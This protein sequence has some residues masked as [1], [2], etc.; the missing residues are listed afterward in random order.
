[1]TCFPVV[2]AYH[3]LGHSSRI[4][5]VWLS[6]VMILSAMS[7]RIGR[8]ASADDG[9]DP[10]ESVACIALPAPDAGPQTSGAAGAPVAASAAVPIRECGAGPC[11][12]LP[13]NPGAAQYPSVAVPET[14]I[15]SCSTTYP[16]NWCGGPGPFAGGSGQS[17]SVA[18][19]PTGI[20][21][22]P[23]RSIYTTI[24]L[25]NAADVRALRTLSSQGL[26]PYWRGDALAQIQSQLAQLQFSGDNATARLYSIQVQDA[27]LDLLGYTATVHTME[28]WLYQERS[29]DSGAVLFSQDEWVRN[30]YDLSFSG[31]SWYITSNPTSLVSGPVPYPVFGP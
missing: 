13:Y 12:I 27:T 11:C 10:S 29:M 22:S 15:G 28:H 4:L 30:E 6:A 23:Y 16:P 26:R 17:P 2:L 24:N 18:A 1:M 8:I 25:G 7:L 19:P 21:C 3:R 14:P 5:L 9:C 31:G 20:Y